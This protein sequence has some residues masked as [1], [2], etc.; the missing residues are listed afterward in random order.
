MRQ[1]LKQPCWLPFPATSQSSV[2]VLES[3]F[4]LIAH[5]RQITDLVL[6]VLELVPGNCSNP[7]TRN[8]SAIAHSKDGSQLR[9]GEAHLESVLDQPDAV[10]RV[11]W[12]IPVASASARRFRQDAQL[13]VVTERIGTDTS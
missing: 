7:L 11:R 9:E 13:L 5:A 6:E 3:S 1:A 12:I 4:K 8:L 2:P 10:E